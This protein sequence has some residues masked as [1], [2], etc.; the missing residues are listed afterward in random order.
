MAIIAEGR[1]LCGTTSGITYCYN[2]TTGKLLWTYTAKDNFH[3][4]PVGVNFPLRAPAALVV[5][6]KIY[7]AYGEH[8]PNNPQPRG[9]P[10]FCLDI[11]TGQEI[12]SQYLSVASYSY[13]PLIGDSIIATLNAYDNRI[14]AMGK[15]PTAT[16]V[17]A[18]P[19]VSVHGSSVLVEGT[20]TDISPG[21]EEY[22]LTAR[23]PNGV[24]AVSD[25]SMS[26]WMRYLHMQFP[27]PTNA[28]GAEV[29]LEVLDPNNN[30][31]E[32]GRT[33]SDS[34]GMYKVSF[35]PQVPG[36]Y[37]IIASF[38]GSNSYWPSK[39]ETAIAVDPAPAAAVVTP[40]PPIVT[41]SPSPTTTTPS[42]TT[43]PSP[44]QAVTP[45]TSAEP[46]TSYIAIGAAVVVIVIAA[47]ALIL[48]RRK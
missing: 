12:W 47:A 34:S 38:A 9:A 48:R 11:E 35:K 16:T 27:R 2:V 17:N 8:S 36:T 19:K 42:Q 26:E 21:T 22:A 31:Y 45:P 23:F 18:S 43:L 3:T 33:T 4:N 5:D 29:V 28:T 13:T 37:T 32:V 25:A 15:G 6:G 40:T 7:G 20:I 30:Y 10:F 24:P 46:T 41:A 14:Y 1:Y 44:T 39:A